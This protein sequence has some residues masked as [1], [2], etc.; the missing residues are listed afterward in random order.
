MSSYGQRICILIIFKTIIIYCNVDFIMNMSFK[1]FE[2]DYNI[3]FIWKYGIILFEQMVQKPPYKNRLREQVNK[4][5]FSNILPN[6]MYKIYFFTI[7][8]TFFR[9][10]TIKWWKYILKSYVIVVFFEGFES[11][12]I[13]N[14]RNSSMYTY[15]LIMF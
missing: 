2:N 9:Y 4:T 12:S 11:F 3:E 13:N 15:A 10:Q 8:H 6:I 1:A 5:V 14:L 7:Y